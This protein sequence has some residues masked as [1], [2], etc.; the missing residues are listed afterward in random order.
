M[1]SV[2][3]F[4]WLAS[5]FTRFDEYATVQQKYLEYAR[6]NHRQLSQFEAE[7]NTNLKMEST[8]TDEVDARKWLQEAWDRYPTLLKALLVKYVEA[9]LGTSENGRL[10]GARLFFECLALANHQIWDTELRVI[11]RHR[12]E[13]SLHDRSTFHASVVELII[14]HGNAEGFA[15]PGGTP[16]I[17][18]MVSFDRYFESQLSSLPDSRELKR[19][20]AGVRADINGQME[21]M[22]GPG[23]DY[24]PRLRK[25][26]RDY[27]L[28]ANAAD[29]ASVM[30]L[31]KNRR[32]DPSV[33][34]GG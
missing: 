30:R 14:H 28:K 7:L 20:I 33:G 19:R 10:S 21:L 1:S 13:W 12:V 16:D 5:R 34:D 31:F 24:A 4:I 17:E 22:V 15:Q 6:A 23:T 29:K 27:Y 11:S 32:F 3:L 9:P 26:I 18:W 2:C 8:D 25:A